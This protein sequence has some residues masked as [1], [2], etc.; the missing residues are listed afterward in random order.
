MSIGL[1]CL[2]FSVFPVSG[3]IFDFEEGTDPGWFFEGDKRWYRTSE[4]HNSSFSMKSGDIDCSGTSSIYRYVEGDGKEPIEISF[5]WKKGG[6]AITNFTFSVDGR[7]ERTCRSYE[8]DVERFT[9]PEDDERHE[10]RW[11]FEKKTCHLQGYGRIDHVFVNI[12]EEK[13]WSPDT[14]DFGFI[15][16]PELEERVTVLETEV[17]RLEGD[18][19]DIKTDVSRLEVESY[20]QDILF[21]QTSFFDEGTTFEKTDRGSENRTSELLSNAKSVQSTINASKSTRESK[22]IYIQMGDDLQSVI[23]ENPIN[24]TFNLPTGYTYI[25]QID[26]NKNMENITIIS[27]DGT[28]TIDGNDSKYV[29][30]LYQTSH[31]SIEGVRLSNGQ[32]GILIDQSNYSEIKGNVINNFKDSGLFIHNS[33]NSIIAENNITSKDFV[34]GIWLYDSKNIFINNNTINVSDYSIYLYSS[35]DNVINISRESMADFSNITIFD[36]GEAYKIYVIHNA[37]LPQSSSHYTFAF[38]KKYSRKLD[39]SYNLWVCKE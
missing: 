18:V 22:V 35:Y 23:N 5:W 17:S 19:R 13:L 25:G 21:N 9:I 38:S 12:E 34:M 11:D 30:G 39:E 8:W 37:R 1:I 3:Y 6:T 33:S 36:N 31:V 14:I 7:V 29:I 2:I 16:V 26:I 27:D 24:T 28:A 20:P 15:H 4:G 32:Y 10:I